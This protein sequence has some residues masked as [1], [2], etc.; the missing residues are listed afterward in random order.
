MLQIIQFH[1]CAEQM[2][3]MYVFALQNLLCFVEK[4]GYKID[5]FFSQTVSPK[6]RF[7]RLLVRLWCNLECVS[8]IVTR[9]QNHSYVLLPLIGH[10]A[11]E[12]QADSVFQSTALLGTVNT[13]VKQNNRR[14]EYTI[15]FSPC[16][17]VSPGLHSQQPG[18]R[19][20]CT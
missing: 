18:V 20:P 11:S 12:A 9:R 15:L 13:F 3:T 6:G 5:L 2:G 4:T 16:C 17:T 19:T 14:S 10:S 1:R 7:S 8:V